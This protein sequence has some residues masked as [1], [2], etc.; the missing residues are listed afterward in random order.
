MSKTTLR[1]LGTKRRQRRRVA[2]KPLLKKCNA[3]GLFLPKL[4]DSVAIGS[5][6]DFVDLSHRGLTEL[7]PLPDMMSLWCN[8]NRLLRLTLTR[9]LTQLRCDEN[10]LTSLPPL[11]PGLRLLRCDKN[12]LT[13]LPELPASLRVL[14]CHQNRLTTLPAFPA[15][16][17]D[18]LCAGNGLIPMGSESPH[19][20]EYRLREHESKVRMMGRVKQYKEELMMNR[21]HPSR[22]ER[23]L[24]A[25]WDVEDM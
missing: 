11:P 7:P 9:T 13:V 3:V 24:I 2:A 14:W 17:V 10:Q 15:V 18:L 20:Y 6:M 8:G 19:Q 16:L 25:G 22:V 23:L 5:A 1:F 21:W 4:T 12:L